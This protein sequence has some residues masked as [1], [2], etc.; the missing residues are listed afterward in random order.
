MLV[1]PAGHIEGYPVPGRICSSPKS[2]CWDRPQ[3]FGI[4]G[5]RAQ[6]GMKPR[7]PDGSH[8]GVPCPTQVEPRYLGC[9]LSWGG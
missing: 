4:K 6:L 7:S 5:A 8:P 2:S 9:W 3:P 1:A